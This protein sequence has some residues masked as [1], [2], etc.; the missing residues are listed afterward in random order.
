MGIIFSQNSDYI[1]E[2][3]C[4]KCQ[5]LFIPSYGGYSKRTSCRVHNYQ[6]GNICEDCNQNKNLG[7]NCYHIRKK[8]Y[9]FEII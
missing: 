8:S 6:E 4:Y 1:C 5:D 7:N 9:C 3:E 2:I